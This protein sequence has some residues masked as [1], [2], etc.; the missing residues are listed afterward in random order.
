MT[1]LLN[2]SLGFVGVPL[3]SDPSKLVLYTH[4]TILI[5]LR[6]TPALF[7]TLP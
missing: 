3:K 2:I 6:Y 5:I 7:A 4:E 1:S